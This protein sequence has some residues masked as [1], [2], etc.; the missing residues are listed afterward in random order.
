[1]QY[2]KLNNMLHHDIVINSD[3]IPIFLINEKSQDN[4]LINV[5]K[6]ID[7]NEE[8]PMMVEKNDLAKR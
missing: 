6:N 4:L 1:M 2:L 5:L 8:I 7:I 3:N